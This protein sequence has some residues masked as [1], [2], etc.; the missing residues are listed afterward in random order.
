MRTWTNDGIDGIVVTRRCFERRLQELFG[1][2]AGGRLMI[3]AR[4]AGLVSTGQRGVHYERP[5]APMERATLIVLAALAAG[6][7]LTLAQAADLVVE[8]RD[9][10]RHAMSVA[11]TG[12]DLVLCHAVTPALVV[13]LT[14]RNGIIRDPILGVVDPV[15]L[16]IAA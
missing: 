13:E 6:T 3:Q 16:E 1:G 4:M 5:L 10:V 8:R 2:I 7:N 15:P 12:E 9:W 11:I 14:I